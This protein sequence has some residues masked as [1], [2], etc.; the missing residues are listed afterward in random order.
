MENMSLPPTPQLYIPVSSRFTNNILLKRLG[1]A[2]PTTISFQQS[3]PLR[4]HDLSHRRSES[5]S[6]WQKQYT[7]IKPL[8][9][10]R[11]SSFEKTKIMKGAGNE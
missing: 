2:T 5:K 6:R 9:C 1:N 3:S 7:I 8:N 10:R 4:C 11:Y